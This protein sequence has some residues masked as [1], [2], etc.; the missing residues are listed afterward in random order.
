M[1]RMLFV[2]TGNTC[3][4]PMAMAV[5]NDIA[6]KQNIEWVA[7][8]AGLSA[9]FDPINENSAKALLKI[10]IDYSDYVSKRLTFGMAD[11]ADLIAVMTNEHKTALVTAGIPEEKILILGDGIPDPFGKDI[12]VYSECLE[13]IQKAVLGLFEEGIIK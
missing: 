8:S 12:E 11:M 5:F 4:S 3:R 10:G 7:D 9:Y 13:K 2:C 1:K 6:E